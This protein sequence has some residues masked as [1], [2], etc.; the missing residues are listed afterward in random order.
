MN[1]S[2]TS[3]SDFC[4]FLLSNFGCAVLFLFFS[5]L[6]FF[7]LPLGTEPNPQSLFEFVIYLSTRCCPLSYLVSYV[8]YFHLYFADLL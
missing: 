4:F 3:Y 2:I 7:P 1:T 6:T 8:F 5:L